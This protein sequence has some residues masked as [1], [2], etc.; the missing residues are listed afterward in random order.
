MGM[1]GDNVWIER[2]LI[3]SPAFRAL[4]TPTA[5]VVLA[6]FWTKRQMVKVGRRGK[7]RWHVSNNDEITLTYREAQRKYGIS[8]SAFRN[9]VDELRD[10]GFV[11]IAESGAGLYK[12]TNKYTIS[13]RWRL[14]DRPDYQPPKQ[15]PRGP[16]NRG[17]RKGNRY[18]CNC[19]EK[20][21]TVEGQHSSTVVVQHGSA[22]ESASHVRERT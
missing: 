6:V 18:G 22:P 8:A 9:A 10:K 13:D 4:G 11:D 17:F 16:V 2:R 21:S 3:E 5:H 7:E 19:H 14:Y 1:K 20:K 12:S 15:R